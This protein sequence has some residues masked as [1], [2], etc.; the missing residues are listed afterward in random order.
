M[1]TLFLLFDFF[2]TN[3]S[4]QIEIKFFQ[5]FEIELSTPEKK[6]IDRKKQNF[7]TFFQW[8]QKQ[9]QRQTVRATRMS[10]RIYVPKE[11]NP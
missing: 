10:G 5:S 9:T 7:L 3:F 11:E 1:T 2:D 6:K 8:L 4:Q